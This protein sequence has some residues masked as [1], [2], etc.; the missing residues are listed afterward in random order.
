MQ[1]I[2][3]AVFT[4]ILGC[5]WTVPAVCLAAAGDNTRIVI[6]LPSRTLEYYLNGSLWR[7][8]PVAIGSPSTPTPLGTFYI[9][10][11]EVNPWWYPPG[12][13]YFVPSGPDNPLGYRWMGFLPTYGIHGTNMPWSVGHVTSSGCI[14]M[15]EEDVE[16]LFDMVAY[17][18]PVIITY[19]R[20][21][22]RIDADGNASAGVYPDVYGYQPVSLT[23]AHKQL[24]RQGLDG[25]AEDAFLAELIHGQ[26][27]QQAAFAHVYNIEVNGRSLVE[28]AVSIAES[29]YI[30]VMPVA[31]VVN[32]IP[33]WNGVDKLLTYQQ[34]TVPAILKGHTIYAS[35]DDTLALLGGSCL[36]K[37][38]RRILSF[39]IP[40]LHYEGQPL[41]CNVQALKDRQY[42]PALAVA[43]ATGTRITWDKAHHELRNG[44]RKIPFKLI[45]DEPYIETAKLSEYFNTFAQWNEER[46]SLDLHYSPA[47]ADCSMYLDLM[48][49][50]VD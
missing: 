25:L 28:H 5:L 37:D 47:F 23:E 13:N 14:R 4:A 26:L 19:D 40:T 42:V 7:E 36:W 12:K 46:Q 43:A 49:D 17:R 22:I 33:A 35:L 44:I 39:K 24:S 8:Y 38:H 9:S 48:S 21:K 6:N 50:F 31:A 29:L 3:L 27:G 15:H 32:A 1:L 2:I 18:T 45:D 20:I 30:P 41:P 16:E 11:K 10:E 34:H